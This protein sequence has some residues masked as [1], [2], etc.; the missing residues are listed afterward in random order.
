MS[1]GPLDT[2]PDP[3]AP[4]RSRKL[5][6]AHG[7]FRQL[8][9]LA[10]LLFAALLGASSL[11]AVA[12]LESLTLQSRDSSLQTL[13]L[14]AQAQSLAER[15]LSLE[16]SARQS[17]VL[18]D[19]VLRERFQAEARDMAHIVLALREVGVTQAQAEQWMQHRQRMTAL[20]QGQPESILER[21]RQLVLQFR[22]LADLHLAMAQQVR[23]TLALR[24]AQLQADLE[25]SRRRLTQQV[26]W[27]VALALALALGLGLWFT[28]PLRHLERAIADLGE[29]RLAQPIAIEGPADLA[30]L[31]RRLDWLR[32]RLVELDADKSRFLRHISHELKTPLASVREGVALLQDGVGGELS[33]DQREIVQILQHQT[34]LLQRQ[35][36]DLL[37]FNEAAFGARHL[38]RRPT[39]LRAL[40]QEQVQAQQLQW[41]SRHLQVQLQAAAAV[42]SEVD[43]DKL[44]TAVGNLLSNAVRFSPEGGQIRLALQCTDGTVRIQVEDQGPGVAPA[45]RG[46]IFEPFYQGQ[47]QPPGARGSGVGLSIVHEYIAAHGGQIRLRPSSRKGCSGAHF[48][49]E[50]PH[51]PPR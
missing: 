20:L 49:I 40:L 45:D 44:G 23:Q 33:A 43:A 4:P 21:E 1:A 34:T 35:I 25:R 16:R 11:Q 27:T 2:P 28:R 37:R 18:D 26:S 38:Q 36:E 17:V 46:R 24:H 42:V 15:S 51:V 6:R 50:L 14:N 7:S 3:A 13:E 9:V 10:F 41:R 29:N 47:W 30:L 8:L 48:E 12:T 19:R 39:D 5:I 22:E 31:G 32:L